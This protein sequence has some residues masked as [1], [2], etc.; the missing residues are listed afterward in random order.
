MTGLANLHVGTSGWSYKHWRSRFYPNGLPAAR[1]LEYYCTRFDTVEVNASFYRLP[2]ERTLRNWRETVGPGFRFALKGSRYVTHV[3]RLRDSGEA[4]ERLAQRIEPLGQALGPILWQLPP[5]LERDLDL[6][7]GFLEGLPASQQHVIEFRD[8]GW[9]DDG[10]CELLASRHV[11]IVSVSSERMPP[12]R[13]ALGGLAYVRFHGLAGGYRHHYTAQE[14]LPW[15]A[16]V[17]DVVSSGG[18]AWVYFNNDGD[19]NAPQDAAAFR[20]MA[21]ERAAA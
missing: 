7:R 13:F 17:A 3:Q 10:V 2:Q 11:G 18:T 1:W 4:V 8:P 14:L 21:S 20:A 15:A 6:L 19:A 5:G 12:R 9:L 16:W